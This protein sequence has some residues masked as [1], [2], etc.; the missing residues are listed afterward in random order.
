MLAYSMVYMR[1]ME[2]Y[3][4]ASPPRNRFPA[5]PGQVDE[6]WMDGSLVGPRGGGS[7]GLI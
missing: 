7:R 4:R 3:P 1:A 6:Q 2:W 5:H